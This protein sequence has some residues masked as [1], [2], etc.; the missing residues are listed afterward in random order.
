MKQRPYLF[1]LLTFVFCNLSNAQTYQIKTGPKIYIYKK[2]TYNYYLGYDSLYYYFFS[3]HPRTKYKNT[4]VRMSRVTKT[5]ASKIPLKFPAKK[6]FSTGAYMENNV[7]KIHTIDRRSRKDMSFNYYEMDPKTGQ[8]MVQKKNAFEQQIGISYEEDASIIKTKSS[9]ILMNYNDLF[10]MKQGDYYNTDIGERNELLKAMMHSKNDYS[11]KFDFNVESNLSIPFFRSHLS[12]IKISHPKVLEKYDLRLAPGKLAL[13]LKIIDSTANGL[14]LI[15][16]Y[17]E[18]KQQRSSFGYFYL[19]LSIDLK[20]LTY[21]V[22]TEQFTNYL[23]TDK[24][25]DYPEFIGMKTPLQISRCFIKTQQLGYVFMF[26]EQ[27][28]KS[29]T[30]IV[31]NYNTNG[32]STSMQYFKNYT[33]KNI[34]ITHFNADGKVTNKTIYV[35]RKGDETSLLSFICEVKGPQLYFLFYDHSENLSKA[36]T[37]ANVKQLY[38]MK[39]AVLTTCNFNL[40]TDELSNKTALEMPKMKVFWPAVSEIDAVVDENDRLH[41]I[42][43][44]HNKRHDRICLY[45]Y[46]LE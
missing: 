25:E 3:N 31:S 41:W 6:E 23:E 40:V 1:V 22:Y 26:E 39:H 19:R 43:L 29:G 32:W 16:K 21:I 11:F 30:N 38:F 15:G 33:R 24:I 45:E 8:L 18:A 9:T 14:V 17:Y 27:S 28:S 10:E 12:K 34:Y 37:D 46:C 4:I 42:Y 7:I 5:I 36:M 44:A 20:P 13:E 35:D 2:G